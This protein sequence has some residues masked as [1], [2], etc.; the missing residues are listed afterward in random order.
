MANSD[1]VD[2]KARAF[3]AEQWAARQK[4]GDSDGFL[5]EALAVIAPEFRAGLD[6]YDD[7]DYGAAAA[8]FAALGD[9]GDPFVAANANAFEVKSLVEQGKLEE[10]LVRLE[11][12]DAKRLADHSTFAAEMAYVRGFCQLHD[13]DYD[14]AEQ[15]LQSF[16][17]VYPGA[18]ARLATSARQMLAE[19]RTRES[20]GISDVTDLMTFAGRRLSNGD[21][22]DRVQERQAKAVE[23]LDKLIEQAEQQEQQQQ[24]SGGGG[25]GGGQGGSN[26][27]NSPMQ[28]SQLPGGSAKDT[29][30]RRPARF[31]RPGDAWGAMPPAEREKVLQALRDSFPS[32]Y[33]QLVEQYYEELAKQP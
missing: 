25:S 20:D 22:G 24:N 13:L 32:R 17:D 15:T 14:A 18:P 5:L 33:R 19:L 23:L 1:R 12:I 28:Q 10:A 29:G 27:P 6:A 3:V 9:A 26:Q 7:G 11:A 4:S 21:S 31:A 2:G 16:L 30:N 8:K